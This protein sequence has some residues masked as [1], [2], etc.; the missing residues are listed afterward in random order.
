MNQQTSSRQ[1]TS[2][3]AASRRVP[4]QLPGLPQALA[5]SHCLGSLG[6]FTTVAVAMI[7]ALALIASSRG[8]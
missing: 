8:G 5:E 6:S 4:L 1:A 2:H 7:S 3:S